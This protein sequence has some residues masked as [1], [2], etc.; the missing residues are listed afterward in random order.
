[1][2]RTAALLLLLTACAPRTVPPASTPP[3]PPERPNNRIVVH[4]N[5]FDSSGQPV[6]HP[7]VRAW[8]ADPSCNPAGDPVQVWGGASSSFEVT[9][10][11]GVGPAERGCL[12]ID[13][14]G[15][16]ATSRRAFP[17]TFSNSGE[18]V[19]RDIT[20]PPPQILSRAEAD[21]VIDV[22]RTAIVSRDRAAVEELAGYLAITPEAAYSRLGD[23]QRHLRTVTEV[24][25]IEPYVYELKGHRDPPL[26]VRVTQDSVTR[27]EL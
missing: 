15:G 9:I 1:M 3:P 26:R 18:R 14:T 8:A 17:V 11:R 5:V 21:R 24:V 25:F 7:R 6:P 22:V 23:I 12:V 16:G 19:E 13:A 27:V 10:E 20:L 2:R 4:G